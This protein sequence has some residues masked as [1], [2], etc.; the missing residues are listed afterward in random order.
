LKVY[1]DYLAR[2]LCWIAGFLGAM[3]F[4]CVDS[5][6]STSNMGTV[7]SKDLRPVN[8]SYFFDW[9]PNQYKTALQIHKNK[10]LIK[11]LKSHA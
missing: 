8:M 6:W 10:S 3:G 9:H 7:N 11:R 1:P 2:V 4:E 5:T